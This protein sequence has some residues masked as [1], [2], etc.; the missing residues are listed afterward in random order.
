MA[1]LPSRSKA[2]S[3]QY[4]QEGSTGAQPSGRKMKVTLLPAINS[5]WVP[6]LLKDCAPET[7]G[8]LSQLLT[9]DA[10]KHHIPSTQSTSGRPGYFFLSLWRFCGELIWEGWEKKRVT[11]LI[12]AEAVSRALMGFKQ[13]ILQHWEE[14][15]WKPLFCKM[16]ERWAS[17]QG[18]LTD[19]CQ[20]G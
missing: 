2:T 11:L 6:Q 4:H 18:V 16:L 10:M 12:F 7:T 19:G 15:W 13:S 8:H 3:S 5:E 1:A 9:V 17:C 14:L 20:S